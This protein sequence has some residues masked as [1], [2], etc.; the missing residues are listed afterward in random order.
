MYNIG[1]KVLYPMQGA[2]VIEGIEVKEILGEER[3]YYVMQTQGNKMK[4]MIPLD[5][6]E[7]IG[8]RELID[9]SVIDD[10]I[11]VLQSPSTPMQNNW[12]K[13]YKD[14]LEKIKTGNIL[15]VADVMRN[16]YILDKKKPLSSGEK[17]ML[18]DVI[19]IITSEIALVKGIT[20][21]EATNMICEVI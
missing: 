13:R 6:C 3:R 16:L 7:Q 5:N 21:E 1:D 19:R 10:V 8:V 20:V 4:V 2:G 15:E 17:K 18:G 12:N 14:N 9:E 11:E